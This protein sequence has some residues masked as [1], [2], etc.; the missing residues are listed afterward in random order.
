MELSPD[1]VD[2]QFSQ[3]YLRRSFRGKARAVRRLP[4]STVL[5]ARRRPRIP[6]ALRAAGIKT[7]TFTYQPFNMT[8][9]HGVGGGLNF[10]ADGQMPSVVAPAAG[11]TG[12]G[13]T[14]WGLNF[15]LQQVNCFVNGTTGATNNAA[16]FNNFQEYVNLF[17]S[18]RI[19]NVEIKMVYNASDQTQTMLT[20][21]PNMLM[22]NDYDDSGNTAIPS[23]MQYDSMRMFQLQA[24]RSKTWKMVPRLQA[25]VETTTG[26]ILAMTPARG[27]WL[28]TLS[29]NAV[30]YG[31]KGAV[32]LQHFAGAL[33]NTGYVTF[34]VKAY[35]EFKNT[36]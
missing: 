29:P 25:Q 19:R 4:K 6:R 27:A 36:K 21:L 13:N 5:V 24:G 16:G 2:Y 7:F 17:D 28:D 30:Y 26:S 33:T 3:P 34:Y 35:A 1:A 20:G 18:Y 22:V 12:F 15:T 14:N 10:Y 9:Q 8:I 23:L 11:A 31:V 32:D